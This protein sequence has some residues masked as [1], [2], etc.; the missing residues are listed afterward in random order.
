MP[1]SSKEIKEILAVLDESGWD[2]ARVTIGD[3]TISVSKDGL[4]DPAARPATAPPPATASAPAAPQAEQPASAPVEPA[5]LNGHVIT[6][7]SVGVF[8]RSPEPGAPPFVEAG[9][10]VAE[11]Q[12]LCIVEVMKL[13]QHV[14]ADVA[15]VVAEV[16]VENSEHVEFGTP[17]FSIVPSSLTGR[18]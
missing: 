15:G 8:W 18:A 13:M 10:A 16:H 14:A 7:P 6:A 3:V 9:D 12:T 2:E 5:A 11:G 1:L 4:L 17:L